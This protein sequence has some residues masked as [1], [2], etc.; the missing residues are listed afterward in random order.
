[1]Q[2][3]IIYSVVCVCV[4]V[5]LAEEAQHCDCEDVLCVGVAVLH[6]TQCVAAALAGTSTD[7]LTLLSQ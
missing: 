2:D 1:M 4:W 6:T 5:C 7:R 3:I